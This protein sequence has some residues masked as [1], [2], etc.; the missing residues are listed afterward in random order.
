MP[1]KQ[2]YKNAKTC[3]AQ[4]KRGE[5]VPR[6]NPL[7]GKYI[8]AGRGDMRLWLANGP[9]FT[10]IDEKNYFGLLFRHWVWFAARGLR[11]TPAPGFD[12]S[13]PVLED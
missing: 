12:P 8:T 11:G 6:W 9:W 13:T 5:W 1:L 4:I 10:D 2:H 3:I 7:S